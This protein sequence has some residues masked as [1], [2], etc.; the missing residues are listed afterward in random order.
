MS[1]SNMMH[2]ASYCQEKK[3]PEKRFR[4]NGKNIAFRLKSNTT[5]P[6]V[7]GNSV[8]FSVRFPNDKLLSKLLRF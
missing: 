7:H 1:S 4:A 6:G 2:P 5:E 3:I 8:C